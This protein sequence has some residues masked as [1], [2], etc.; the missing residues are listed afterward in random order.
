[1]NHTEAVELVLGQ[2]HEDL[3]AYT[4]DDM[5]PDLREALIF[6]RDNADLVEEVAH[7]VINELQGGVLEAWGFAYEDYQKGKLD[8]WDL[9]DQRLMDYE[10][11]NYIAAHRIVGETLEWPPGYLETA[12]KVEDEE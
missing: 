5:S 9:E 6:L 7:S 11:Q 8:L 1:M 4:D 3:W 10:E 12:L 2:Y